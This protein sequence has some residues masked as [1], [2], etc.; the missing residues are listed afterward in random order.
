MVPLSRGCLHP[1]AISERVSIAKKPWS[2]ILKAET[3]LY[4]MVP[5]G[6]GSGILRRGPKSSELSLVYTRRKGL[7]GYIPNMFGHKL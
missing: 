3:Q 4:T 6:T 2:Q 1:E 5:T 7:F